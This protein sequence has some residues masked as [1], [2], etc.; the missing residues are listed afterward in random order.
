M[1]G[2]LKV[3]GTILGVGLLGILAAKY[4][5]PIF[6][7]SQQRSTSDAVSTKG[8]LNIGMDNWVGYFPLCSQQMQ[9]RMR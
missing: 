2:H 6:Q 8:S 7:E 5:L 3:A 9:A 1:S 4:L